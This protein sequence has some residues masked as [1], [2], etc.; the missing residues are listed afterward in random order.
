MATVS[1]FNTPISEI[2]LDLLP[3]AIVDIYLILVHREIVP[4]KR[5]V[6]KYLQLLS[7]LLCLLHYSDSHRY[8]RVTWEPA[9]PA[10]H[11]EAALSQLSRLSRSV[12]QD[13]WPRPRVTIRSGPSQGAAGAIIRG[14]G[15]GRG[16]CR[17][18]RHIAATRVR[19]TEKTSREE[20]KIW[21]KKM[22]LTILF[23]MFK[24]LV[25]SYVFSI[26]CN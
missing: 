14:P 22:K 26:R 4:L 16:R 23:N 15:G 1:S 25:L 11:D 8:Q 3:A 24:C 10:S 18:T 17:E 7:V 20:M 9:A 5:S 6:Q 19:G 21:A 13:S 2:K 12:T